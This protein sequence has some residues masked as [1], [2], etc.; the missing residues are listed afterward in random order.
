MKFEVSIYSSEGFRVDHRSVNWIKDFR[1][2]T[3]VSLREAKNVCDWVRDQLMTCQQTSF[4][5]DTD[6]N[7]DFKFL[8]ESTTILAGFPTMIKV[9]GKTPGID[10]NQVLKNTAIRLI[11]MGAISQAR[12]VLQV[13]L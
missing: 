1:E 13:L 2:Q 11:R 6:L 8:D 7:Q 10:A 5:L 9:A 12:A 3:G 4:T